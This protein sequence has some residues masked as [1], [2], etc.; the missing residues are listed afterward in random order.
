MLSVEIVATE[1]A[2]VGVVD[3]AQGR[4]RTVARDLMST[5]QAA[6]TP[7]HGSFR[8]AKPAMGIAFVDSKFR[9]TRTG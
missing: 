6:P 5:Q 3:A 8:T 9:Q 2:E 1:M 7:G 4:L